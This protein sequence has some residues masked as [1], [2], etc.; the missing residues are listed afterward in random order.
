MGCLHEMKLMISIKEQYKAHTLSSVVL[1]CVHCGAETT[2][3]D[4]IELGIQNDGRI[5]YKYC[6]I[7]DIIQM[8]DRTK[9]YINRKC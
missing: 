8:I 3:Y 4:D 7:D 6:K 5:L 2:L 9:S 1:Q